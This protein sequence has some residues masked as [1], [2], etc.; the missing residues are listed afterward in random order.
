MT[1]KEYIYSG[2]LLIS[3]VF[4]TVQTVRL[5]NA[6]SFHESFVSA[7]KDEMIETGI[8]LNQQRN[9]TEK[10]QAE[11][12]NKYFE[13]VNDANKLHDVTIARLN[14][15]NSQLQKHW[16][17]ALRRADSA[18]AALTGVE[19]DA[20]AAAVSTDIANLLRN[21]A[22]GDATIVSLQDTINTYLCQINKEPYPGYACR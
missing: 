17:S 13:G 3:L 10:A 12:G 9:A 2:L 15:D 7:I 14:A 1:P 21:T 4:G 18:E 6:K 19:L 16:R 8:K 22:T 20:A 5:S 11:I